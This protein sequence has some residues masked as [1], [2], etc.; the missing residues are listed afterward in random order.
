MQTDTIPDG[1]EPRFV[2]SVDLG[3]VYFSR[4]R[5]GEDLFERTTAVCKENGIERAVILSGVGSLCDVGFRNLRSG[6]HLPVDKTKTNLMEEY[7]PFELLTLEGTIVPLVG[8][9]GDLKEGDPVLHA[10]ATLGQAY[11]SLIGGHLVKAKV[12]TTVEILIAKIRNST[13]RKKQ[14]PVTGLT[15]MRTDV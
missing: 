9:F 3:E 7:G 13:V 1:M 11:G 12:Y 10:H 8:T 5:P 6:I 2:E 15:E 14:S 4:F